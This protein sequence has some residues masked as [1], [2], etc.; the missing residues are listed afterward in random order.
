MNAVSILFPA[1]LTPSGNP[2]LSPD[3]VECLHAD[4]AGV[5]VEPGHSEGRNNQGGAD[6]L[7]DGLVVLTTYRLIWMVKRPGNSGVPGPQSSHRNHESQEMRRDGRDSSNLPPGTS[8][9]ALPLASV[10]DASMARKSLAHAFASPR[11]LLR[12]FLDHTG[13][14]AIRPSDCLPN[15]TATVTLV[16]RG[17]ATDPDIFLKHVNELL[18]M[19]SWQHDVNFKM[20]LSS[21]AHS[22]LSNAPYQ[23]PYSQPYSD[24]GYSHAHTNP[25]HQQQLPQIAPGGYAQ[26]PAPSGTPSSADLAGGH[27]AVARERVS[28]AMAGVGGLLRRE[29][30]QLQQTDRSLQEA[31]TDLNALMVSAAER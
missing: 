29:Q 1:P 25:L 7:R 14:P 2:H 3:E 11:I 16:L 13:R 23:H 6:V 12:T 30:E 15:R 31:F 17:K 26:A 28:P 9:V 21:F 19:K 20:L 24:T 4:E 22:S 18:Y 8:A 10:S 5:E 27:V